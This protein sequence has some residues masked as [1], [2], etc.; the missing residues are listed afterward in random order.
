MYFVTFLRVGQKFQGG[1]QTPD[2]ANT[3][4]SVKLF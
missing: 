3:S 1:V 4:N 2:I